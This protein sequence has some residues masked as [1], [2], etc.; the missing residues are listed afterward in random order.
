MGLMRARVRL[1]K[2]QNDA[3]WLRV[4]VFVYECAVSLL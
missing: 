3:M 1:G 2:K 4:C